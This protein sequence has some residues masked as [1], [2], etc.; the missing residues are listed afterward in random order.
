MNPLSGS[1][2]PL[3]RL[4][5]RCLACNEPMKQGRHAFQCEPR[6]LFVV[7]FVVSYLALSRFQRAAGE[8]G[9]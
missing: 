5:S 6:W 2:A 8:S 9:N 1:G 3:V 7:F 4:T